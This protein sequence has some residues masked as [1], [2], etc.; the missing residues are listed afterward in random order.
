VSRR[1]AA[2]NPADA[3]W[4][5]DPVQIDVL[6]PLEVR[7]AGGS[8]VPVTGARLRTLL[9]RLALDAGRPVGFGV[10]VDALWGDEPP[11]DEANALQTLVSRLRRA[12][13]GPDTVVQSQAGYRLAVERDAVDAARFERLAADG[14]QALRAGDTREAARVLAVALA[15]WRGPALAD[16][17]GEA[18]LPF[19]ARL[20]DL[21]LAA[22]VD[23]IDA[24]LAI[25]DPAVLVPELEALAAAH[26]LHERV[27]G[28]LMRALGASGRQAD[29]LIAYDRLRARLADELGVDPGADVQQ[30]H[31]ELLRGEIASRPRP[32]RRTNLKA[33]LT[34]FVGRE[35]EVA[36]IGKSLEQHRLVTLV[37]PGG[38]GKTR[39]A[40]EATA[41]VGDSAAD[42]VWFVEL[43][44]VT[45]GADVPQAVLG[46]LGLREAHLLDRRGKLSA[47]DA[48]TRLLEALAGAQTLLVLDNCEHVIDASA[49]LADQLLAE[50][51]DLRILTTSR[52]P[53][54][55]FGELLL[56]VPPLNQP[57]PTAGADEAL[58]Y[59][60]VRLFADRAATVRPDFEVSDATVATVVEIVRR[61]DGLPLAIELAAARLRSLPVDEIARRLT[62]RFRLLTG[63]SR[64]ALPRHRTLR[65]VVEWSWDLLTD[66]ERRFAE[67]LAVFPSGVTV[68]TATAVS[69]VA[70]DDVPDLIA[71]LIDKSLLQPID[72]GR[73]AR[74]LETIREYGIERLGERG[75]LGAVRRRH[76]DYFAKLLA[77]AEPH[78]TTADQ[79]PWFALIGDERDNLVAAMRYRCD[80]G[81][82]DGALA[83]AVA[84]S[85]Y[86]MMLGNHAEI[87][88]WTGDAL[89]VE[90]GTDEQLRLT[91]LAIGAM[92]SAANESATEDVVAA[93]MEYLRDLAH[94]LATV[95][96]NRSRFIAILRAAV[97]YFAGDR[98]LT[99]RFIAE[100]LE[101]DDPWS[102]AGLR[103]F[104]AAIA[105]N[106]GDVEGMRANTEL[107]L[108]EFRQIGERWG[109][110]NGL[111]LQA[112]LQMLDGRLDEAH[113]TYEEALALADELK[114]RD[115][116]CLLLG[117]LA[118]IEIRRGDLGRAR[119]Y[120]A[121]AKRAADESGALWES[122]FTMAML[123]AIE[124]RAGNRD[125]ARRLQREAMARAAAMPRGHPA[126]GHLRAILL[127]V[128]ARVAFE[129]GELAEARDRAA[130]SFTAAV[131]TR[132][133]PVIASVGVTLAELAARS[134]EPAAAAM[135]LGAAARLRG[136]DDATAPDIAD[137]T[138]LIRAELGGPRFA[139]LYAQGKALDRPAAI[140]RLDPA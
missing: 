68:D 32:P 6:G 39:L 22:A 65:A 106:D 135:M 116:E 25:G 34:S 29:A 64:T 114:S 83:M 140:E 129:D 70:G 128:G 120:I 35:E 125:E 43:A 137:L 8:P 127:A 67:Q 3:A 9:T 61:L 109:L 88:T 53:L 16:S 48:I 74:M 100:T 103:M 123:G 112:Q 24:D 98:E 45:A 96:P 54:G 37:G 130:E 23:R 110:A 5:S 111:R 40:A 59:P 28:Q 118:D 77:E 17:T 105:E 126:L 93:G 71:S 46:S 75:E 86:A 30:I 41:Q 19:A 104:R 49:R 117:R 136:A 92:H 73:R 131:G 31:V 95:E 138:D 33:Q 108:A 20:E 2:T 81:D 57:A 76:A 85:S 10:L 107:A 91:A 121:R 13:G 134:G 115:D 21:R 84:L 60:A 101:S 119:E 7:D 62:D 4:D 14:A 102:R 50:C 58:E 80:I 52:E 63:G 78:L 56:A 36:R 82:A 26:P 133:M 124:H 122:V 1:S 15:L 27:A 89:A 55:I 44:Q 99:E 51:P 72:D 90:G 69:D 38:A 42:G 47:R 18:L 94:R 79:L 132:D 12:L 66:E 11:A 87:A 97:A 139:E 113:E